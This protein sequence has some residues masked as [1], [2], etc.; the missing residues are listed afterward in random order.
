VLREVRAL[1]PEVDMLYLA[2]QEHVPYGDRSLEEVR[3]LAEDAV[4]LLIERGA[5]T[6][7]IACNSASAASIRHVRSVFP[8]TPIVGMEPAVKPAAETSPTGV[9]GV[10]ATRATFLA[11]GFEELVGKYAEGS[12]V[13]AHPCPGWAD[14]VEDEWPAGAAEPIRAHLQPLIEAGVDTLVLACTHYSFLGPTITDIVGDAVA[15]VDPVA[16]VAR[17]TARVAATDKGSGATHYLTTGDPQ[18]LTSQ[19]HRLI[20]ERVVAV[21]A[22]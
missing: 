21:S 10:L 20:G 22:R 12:Q 16:A 5:T 13:I 8:D 3:A 1:L 7:V 18:R 2:D 11:A 4:R 15:V 14:A 9:I 6:V 17:Q 19:V